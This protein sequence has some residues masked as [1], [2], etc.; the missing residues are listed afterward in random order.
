M[1][2]DDFARS[3]VA[4]ELQQLWTHLRLLLLRALLAARARYGG[5]QPGHAPVAAI[6]IF[7]YSVRDAVVLDWRKAAMDVRALAGVPRSWLSGSGKELTRADFERRWCHRGVIARTGQHG[8]R[9]TMEFR[10][11]AA[12]VPALPA[13][14]ALA[15]PAA[16]D[17]RR[18]GGGAA[19][20][21]SAAA[22]CR[23]RGGP[24]PGLLR[25]RWL[26]VAPLLQRASVGGVCA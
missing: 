5:G 16:Q 6:R 23:G 19:A 22:S 11:T 3:G 4:P 14:P 2:A 7:V 26:R 12:G 8:G 18:R 10:L 13:A 21:R 15:P 17:P 24:R 1:L 9:F 20:A 25:P